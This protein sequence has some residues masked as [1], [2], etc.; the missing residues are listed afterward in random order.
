MSPFEHLHWTVDDGI[1]WVTMDRPPVNAVNQQMYHE[2]EGGLLIGQPIRRFSEGRRAERR[3]W[4]LL[5]W[6]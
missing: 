6:K 2:F 3:W 5:C 1:A 4:P